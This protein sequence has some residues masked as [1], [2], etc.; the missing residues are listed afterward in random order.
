MVFQWFLFGDHYT[1]L[2]A[3]ATCALVIHSI[4]ARL[5]ENLSSLVI[6]ILQEEKNKTHILE[7]LPQSG[8]KL[9]YFVPDTEL[10]IYRTQE[11]KRGTPDP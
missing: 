2:L 10:G 6:R 8:N 4:S 3:L 11:N 7:L 9:I 5:L 1:L